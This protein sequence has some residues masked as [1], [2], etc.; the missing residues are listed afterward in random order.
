MIANVCLRWTK[1]HEEIYLYDSGDYT[2][3][4]IRQNEVVHYCM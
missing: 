1:G 2:G 4:Y 3:I